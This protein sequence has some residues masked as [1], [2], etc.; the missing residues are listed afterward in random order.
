ML[1]MEKQ[2][3]KRRQDGYHPRQEHWSRSEVEA[4]DTEEIFDKLYFFGVYISEKGFLNQISQNNSAQVLAEKWFD[5]YD[6]EVDEFDEDFPFLAVW[7]L[8][9]RLAPEKMYDEKLD[10][11]MMQGY[12]WIYDQERLHEGC[13]LWLEFWDIFR[14]RIPDNIKDINET[15]N[16]FPFSQ[17]LQNWVQDMEMNLHNAAANRI[18]GKPEYYYKLKDFLEEFLERFPESD[19]GIIFNMR[20]ALAAVYG[21]IGEIEEAEERY[22]KLVQEFPDNAF[23]YIGWGD[24]Y[25]QSGRNSNIEDIKKARK[26]Y[27]KAIGKGLEDEDVALER[28]EDLENQFDL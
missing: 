5:R 19:E 7:V 16:V 9:E 12:R 15:N 21:D 1:R 27:Q 8:W 10:A 25:Y 22:K 24:M 13:D 3:R 20:R 26:L 4:M 11:L 18:D 28:L 14:E 6:L 17:Y 2:Q 23:A